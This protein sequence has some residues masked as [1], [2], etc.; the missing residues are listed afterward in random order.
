M[1]MTITATY[2]DPAAA[3]NAVDE[4]I[5]RG[6]PPEQIFWPKDSL[7]VR[8]IVPTGEPEEDVAEADDPDD[9]FRRRSESPEPL[10]QGRRWTG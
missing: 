2:R 8:V 1:T 10:R 5:N 9:P 7:Q 3:L 6:V 4:L